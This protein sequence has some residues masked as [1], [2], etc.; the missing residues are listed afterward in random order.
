MKCINCNKETS[1]PRF[2][3]RSCAASHNNKFTK[4]K[5]KGNCLN[6]GL[7]LVRGRKYCSNKCQAER[8]KALITEQILRGEDVQHQQLRRYLIDTHGSKC[9]LCGWAKENIVTNR[10]PIE[11]DH[12]DGNSSNNSLSNLRLLCPNCHSIQPTHKALNRGNGRHSR[13]QR[14]KQGKS[15]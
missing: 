14:Y 7:S 2:C 8:T 3:N 5:E 12:I 9:M 6:C 1:N 13:M 15:Y 4:L 10:V 11:L